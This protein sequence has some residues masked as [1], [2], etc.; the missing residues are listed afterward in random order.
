MDCIIRKRREWFIYDKQKKLIKRR[1]FIAVTWQTACQTF[2]VSQR[3]TKDQ[4]IR[5]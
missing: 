1:G 3:L 4:D 5:W 2:D